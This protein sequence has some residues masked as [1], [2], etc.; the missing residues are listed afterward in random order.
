MIPSVARARRAAFLAFAAAALAA[1]LLPQAIPLDLEVGYRWVDVSGNERMYRTQI[2]DRQGLLLRSFNYTLSEPLGGGLLDYFQVDAS[3]IGAGPAGR[4]R[5]QAGAVDLYKLTFTWRQTDLYSALPAFANPFLAEGIIPGQQTYN[6]QRNIY[7]ATLQLLPGKIISPILQFTRNTYSGPGTTTYHLGGNEFQLN[8]QVNS[9]DDLYRLGFNFQYGPVQ[10]GV[11]QGWRYFRWNQTNTLV[12]GAGDGNVTTPVL[13]QDV[14]ADAIASVQENKTNTPVTNAWVTGS[15]FGRLK[16][17]GSY[18]KADGSNET[19]YVE[20]DAGNF[21][22]FEI[23]R[24]F[25]GLGETVNSRARTDYWQGSARAEFDVTSNVQVAG[26]WSENSRTLTGQA[27]IASL[28]LNTVTF[29]G[30]PAGDLL[31]EIDARTA[32]ERQDTVFDAG[33]TAQMLGPFS[34]NA[35]WSQLQQDVLATPDASEIIV[36]GGQGGEFERTVNTFGGGFT[37]AACG[38][39]LTGDYRH[40]DANQPIFRTDFINRDRYKFRALWNFKDFLKVGAVFSE[41]HADDDIVEI[42]YRAKVRE[43]VADVEVSLLKNMLTLRASGGEFATNREILIRIPQ[44]FEIVPTKQKEFGHTWEGGVH[45]LWKDF[46]LDAAYLWMNN[47]GSIPFTVDR[48][49]VVADWF[50]LKN[51]GATFEW[52]DDKYSERPAFDQ[53]GALADY[54]GNRYYVGLHWRP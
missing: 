39:T 44:D 53:A 17:I 3:D 14:T 4:L 40:D 21:V 34:V 37:F 5:L 41:T 29:A 24:F 46:S 12:P 20:G 9:V 6:R 47:N 19:R 50:F 11:T 25:A 7:D 49:R 10:G 2:N 54:N 43:F 18:M 1:P 16:L 33:V 51:L 22:S 52:L 35:G 27:L 15:L 36:P 32:V 48:F 26:G 31:Q 23:S 8:D 13:G 45:F 38:V 42:G 28:Y 30:V